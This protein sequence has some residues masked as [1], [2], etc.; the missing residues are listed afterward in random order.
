[1][2]GRMIRQKIDGGVGSCRLTVNVN[3]KV[4]LVSGYGK[5]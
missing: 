1:M 2:F 5:V 3:I 4:G